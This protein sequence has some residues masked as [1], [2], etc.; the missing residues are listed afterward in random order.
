[1]E[2]YQTRVIGMCA[3]TLPLPPHGHA[4]AAIS[5][6]R[7]VLVEFLRAAN[8]TTHEEF[9]L[10]KWIPDATQFLI[11][12]KYRSSD[13]NK[14]E[15]KNWRTQDYLTW[16]IPNLKLLYPADAHT[17]AATPAERIVALKPLF[18]KLCL[19]TE[20]SY[21]KCI[22][23]MREIFTDPSAVALEPNEV[24]ALIKK[25]YDQMYD[26]DNQVGT[27]HV[28]KR[29]REILQEERH[30]ATFE[31]VYAARSTC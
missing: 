6:T 17:V 31:A 27:N 28:A 30:P 10:N 22:L 20:D 1:M 8:A 14:E 16:L 5:S 13:V 25:M 24:K 18:Q 26:K 19:F 9:A 15:W 23:K 11:D 21:Q 7:L 3:H 4:T 29:I 2:F 12:Q